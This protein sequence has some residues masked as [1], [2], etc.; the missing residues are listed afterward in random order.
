MTLRGHSSFLTCIVQLPDGRLV[1]G[2]GDK[3]L[4]TWNLLNGECQRECERIVQGHTGAVRSLV[5]LR[6]GRLASGADDNCVK[7]WCETEHSKTFIALLCY[8]LRISVGASYECERTLIG[9][10]GFVMSLLE[11][12]GTD[13][14]VSGARDTVMK[15]WNTNDGNGS[16]QLP[17]FSYL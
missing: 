7:I 1:T 13:I 17:A 9:H 5:V 12:P 2:S 8:I 15:A 3:D 10:T 6:D 14:I 11:V 16:R 4:R